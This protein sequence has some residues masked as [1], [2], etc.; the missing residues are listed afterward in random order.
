[1]KTGH[2]RRIP[3]NFAPDMNFLLF[4]GAKYAKHVAHQRLRTATRREN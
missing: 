1:M 2:L 4:Y 3:Y